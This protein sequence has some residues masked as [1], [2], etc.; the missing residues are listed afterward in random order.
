[1]A[2]AAGEDIRV[3]RGEEPRAAAAEAETGHQHP[4][5]VDVVVRPY[6]PEQCHHRL[7]GDRIGP[8]LRR[9]IG[10]DDDGV[11]TVEATGDDL[12]DEGGAEDGRRAP[13]GCSARTSGRDSRVS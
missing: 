8:R 7:V 9:A 13:P 1:M 10:R 6:A 2:I 12:F 3:A 4:L 5:A 11:E